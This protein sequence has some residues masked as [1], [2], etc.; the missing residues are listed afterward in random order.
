MKNGV[1][2]ILLG[3]TALG[4]CKKYVE[5]KDLDKEIIVEIPVYSIGYGYSTAHPNFT[6]LPPYT[7]LVDF[8]K[9]D[10]PKVDSITL[11]ALLETQYASDTAVIRLFNVTDNVAIENS[12]LSYS[13]PYRD[14]ARLIN[15]NNLYKSLPDKRVT[16]AI[17]TRGTGLGGVTRTFLKLRRN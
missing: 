16:L 15:T 8:D 9:R 11:N 14:S 6:S 5:E 13:T 1:L 10:Y 4:S 7:Y 12:S 2:F 3:I 17:Q